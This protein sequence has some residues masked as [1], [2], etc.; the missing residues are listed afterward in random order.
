MSV[1]SCL[2]GPAPLARRGRR[3]KACLAPGMTAAQPAGGEPAAPPRAMADQGFSGVLR[4]G[5]KEPALPPDQ[6]RKRQ[7]VG[8]QRA[9]D[10]TFVE[11]HAGY[12]C[13]EGPPRLRR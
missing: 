13:D 3:I 11:T 12:G 4:A 9:P 1:R 8:A 6:R 2:T 10:A 7:L 5:R